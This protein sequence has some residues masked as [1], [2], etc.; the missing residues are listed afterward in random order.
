MIKELK[1]FLEFKKHLMDFTQNPQFCCF[2][3]HV[4]KFVKDDDS[5]CLASNKDFLGWWYGNVNFE[6]GLDD[7]F[8]FEFESL[9]TPGE[10]L[11]T[12]DIS[13]PVSE[14]EL[15]RSYISNRAPDH[16]YRAK[17]NCVCATFQNPDWEDLGRP[18]RH[19]YYLEIY[20]LG[21]LV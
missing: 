18:F 16:C 3:I 14:S 17:N 12:T 11:K 4:Y 8:H 20:P 9:R 7:D 2:L 21:I 19:T 10:G 13:I 15:L 6:Q 5:E 1:S